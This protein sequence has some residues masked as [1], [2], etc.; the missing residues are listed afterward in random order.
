MTEP[1]FTSLLETL[2]VA[3]LRL[4]AAHRIVA[5]NPAAAEL[6]GGAEAAL[7]GQPLAAVYRVVD[8]DGRPLAP[9]LAERLDGRAAGI[10]AGR[11][12][13]RDGASFAI[14]ERWTPFACDGGGGGG[15]LVIEDLTELRALQR[16]QT[17]LT[18]HDPVT[19]LPNRRAFERR[20]EETLS[21]VRAD[22]GSFAVG[23]LDVDDF[24]VVHDTWG[25]IA[26]DELVRQVAALIGDR[27]DDG[28][29]VARL[30]DV[31][32]GIL[33]ERCPA[34]RVEARAQD[35]QQSIADFRFSW[36]HETFT[37]GASVGMVPI[38]AS[39][40]DLVR[41]LAAADAAST[42]A[43]DDSIAFHRF[44]AD[45][46]MDA[47]LAVHYGEMRWLSR[48]HRALKRGTLELHL[49]PIVPTAAPDIARAPIWEVLL[50]M[51]D[52]DGSLVLP[53]VFIPAA[54]HFH[55]IASLDRWVVR[56]ALDRLAA[57]E[58]SF[59]IA[60]NLSGQSISEAGF[61]D[62][63][64]E[65][66]G[67]TGANP[68]RVCFEITETAAVD[69]LQRA[70]RFIAHLR[71]R[72]CRFVLDD[73]G[74]GLSSF[75][76]L[77]ELAVDFL[78]IDGRFVRDMVDD[79]VQRAIVTAVHQVGSTMGLRTIA[80]YVES[81]AILASLVEIGVDYAQGFGI[82]RPEPWHRAVPAP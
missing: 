16:E 81:E 37:L 51:V 73:F 28:D 66:L 67:A 20:V 69:N 34:D 70:R 40:G 27:L 12:K 65:Q 57:A 68:H 50:R 41:V 38:D 1:M 63:V 2:G 19:G 15:W 78:K 7:Q 3:V 53:D 18:F 39:S 79:P 10:E 46:T 24:E 33:I 76:Y 31:R 11:L 45:D 77:K 36:Q 25:Q 56:T 71:N 13:R 8:D 49:Q 21:G 23:Y 17:W 9:G 44:D 54:E 30:G 29:I 42:M 6:L 62:Y 4:D 48:I 47:D 75:G 72:G 26:G 43:K 22:G 52:D 60:I 5:L 32:F 14:R 80:E 82:R 58:G 55:L 74:S 35:L 61:L 59:A 64:I